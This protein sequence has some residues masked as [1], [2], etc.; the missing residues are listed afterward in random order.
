MIKKRG[1]SQSV[2]SIGVYAVTIFFAVIFLVPFYFMFILTTHDNSSMAANPPPFWIGTEL[3]M[4]FSRLFRGTEYLRS[5]FN[6]VI[7]ALLSTSTRIFFCSMAG[8]AFAKYEFRGK[9]F[10]FALILATMMLPKFLTIVPLYSMMIGLGWINTY[11][12]LVVPQMAYSFGI[13]LMT[14]YIRSLVPD[15]LLD[16]AKIDGLTGFQT[17]LRIIFPVI[18]P[19]IGV[20]ATVVFVESWNDFMTSL[21]MLPNETMYTIPVAIR[22]LVFRVDFGAVMLAN[23][24]AVTPLFL[25]FLVF[26]KKFIA[27]LV[28]GNIK[29]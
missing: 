21:L 25:I 7:V 17:L 9:K 1:V 18:Q 13:F 20:L 10:F 16:A 12:P 4:T 28:S 6:S 24:F 27:N 26:S 23:V 3:T 5:I 15:A 22:A 8:F 11:F 2:R 29:G 19:A 14:Q